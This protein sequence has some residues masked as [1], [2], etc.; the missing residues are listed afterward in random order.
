MCNFLSEHTQESRLTYLGMVMILSS[1][2]DF[3]IE[4]GAR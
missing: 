4:K 3:V 1:F 2:N